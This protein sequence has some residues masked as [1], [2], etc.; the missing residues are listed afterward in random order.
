[1]RLRWFLPLL[2]LCSCARPVT[3]YV[4]PLIGSEGLGRVFVGPACPFG[5]VKPSPDCTTAPNSGWLPMPERVDGFAQTH[6]SGTG[7]GPKYGNI[8][9]M[10]QS[11]FDPA[12]TFDYRA[13]ETIQPGYYSTTFERSGIGVEVTAAPRVSAYRIHYPGEGEPVLRL[14]LD[15]FLGRSDTP[16]A[17]EAQEFVDAA[18]EVADECHLAGYQTIRGGWNN[19]APYTV[20]FCLQSDAPFVKTV[21]EGNVAQVAFDRKE[22]EVRIGI[23]YLGAERA[24]AN[25][26]EVEGLSFGGIRSACLAEW[27][28]LLSRVKVR[29]RAR[30][31]RMF[32]TALYHTMLMPVD[33]TGEWAPAGDEVYYDDYYALWDTYRT[34]LPLITLLDPARERDLVNALLTIYR[35]DGYLPDARSGNSNGRTQGG[36]NAEIV[37]ADAYVKGLE[38]I[39]YEEALRAMLHDAEVSPADDEAEGRGG[40]EEYRKLGYI[41]WGIPRAG[42]RTVEYAAC[43]AAIAT[44]AEGLGKEDIAAAYRRMSGNWKNL[45]R[46]DVT[47]DGVTGFIMPRDAS[48]AWLDHLPFGHSARL[49]LTYRYTPTMAEG[50]WY[51]KWWSAF[52]YEGSSWEY[53]LS[54]PHDVPGLVEMCGGEDAFDARLDRFFAGGYYNVAN[55]PSF[56]TPCLYHWIG[57]PDKTSARVLQIIADHFDDTPAGL[58]GND[59]SGAMSSWL[60]FHQMGLYP[61]AGTDRYVVHAPVFERTEIRLSN[62][63]RFIVKAKGLSN[64]RLHIREAR[65]D[66]RRLD[67]LFLTHA[68]LVRGGTLTLYMD[69]DAYVGLQPSRKD[70]GS[71]LE[72]PPYRM[73]CFLHGQKRRFDVDLVPQGDS[74]RLEWGI[75]RNLKGWRGSYTMTPQALESA[76]RLSFRM[77]EDGLQA[78]LDDAVF[79]LMPRAAFR[80]LRDRGRASFNGTQYLLEDSLEVACCRTLLHARDVQEGAEIWVLNNPSRPLIWRMQGNPAEV[81]WAFESLDPGY[82]AVKAHPNRAGGSYYAYPSPSLVEETPA[83][84][85]YKPFYVSH[86][87]RHGSRYLTRDDRYSRPLEFWRAQQRKGNLTPFG[88]DFLSRLETLWA[89]VEG[90]GGTLSAVGE[91]QHREIAGRMLDRYP[92]LFVPG[93]VVEATSST[94]GRCQASMDAFC[95]SLLSACP[96]LSLSRRSDEETMAVLVPKNPAID[97]L[98]RDDAPWRTTAYAR[99]KAAHIHPQRVLGSLLKDPG[100]LSDPMEVASDLYYLAVGLQDIPTGVDMSDIFTPEELY[101]ALRCVDSRMYY[102]HT[103]CPASGGTGPY[104]VRPLLRDF[105]DKADAAVAGT[106]PAAATLR[107]GHDSILIRLLSLLGVAECSALETDPEKYADAWQGWVVSPMAANLQLVLYRGRG[108]VKVKLLLNEHETSIPALGDG[109][110]YDWED[111]RAYAGACAREPDPVADL[112][113]RMEPGS[114]QRIAIECTESPEAFFEIDRRAGKPLIRADSPVHAAVGLNW[115]LKYYCGIHL[116][117][118]RMTASLPEDLPLP[119]KPERHTADVD[120]VYDFNYCTYSYSMAFW[121]WE[122]WERELDW[123]ALHGVD[124]PLAA[125]GDEC[126]WRNLL[127]RLGYSADEAAA[128]IPGPAYLAWFEM[129][130]IEGWGGPLPEGW[131]SCQEALQRQILARMKEWGMRPVLPGYSGMVPHDAAQRLGL[132]APDQGLWNQIQCPSILS[133]TDK[134][135][136]EIAAL[137][138]REQELLFGKADFYSMDPFH[139]SKNAGGVDFAKAGKAVLKAMKAVSPDAVW[140][141]QAWSDN[142]RDEMLAA[143]PKGDVLVLDLFSEC[144]PKWGLEGSVWYNEKGFQGHDWLFCLLQDFGGRVGLHGR[145]GELVENY[146]AARES[147]GLRGVGY[148]MEAIGSNPVMY[149]LM[150]ELPWRDT[151]VV[152]DW[153]RDYAFARY[154]VRDQVLEGA[155]ELLASSIYDARRPNNQQ[156]PVESVFCARPAWDAF[157]VY[158]RSKAEPYYD[159]LSVR[160]AAALMVSVAWRYRGNAHFEYDLV[161]LVRQALADRARE[162][163]YAHDSE[164]FMKALLAQDRLLGCRP[165]WMVGSWIAEALAKAEEVAPGDQ[166]VRALFER[167]AR[168]QLTTWGDRACADEGKLHD[169]AYKEW[170]GLLRDFYAKRWQ[171]F[172]DAETSEPGSGAAI[173]WYA[174]EEPWALRSDSYPAESLSNPVDTACEVFAQF[175]PGE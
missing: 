13:D 8:L 9:I 142:P 60:A 165:E 168:M 133:P 10:P 137:Y 15:F 49:P 84:K 40:L 69:S 34:S 155:W 32:Y 26:K 147:E 51:T 56:L 112:L 167:N 135:F 23:S 94:S 74:L 45:W 80:S 43:D 57:K 5:M 86:Y 111:F 17:R 119:E 1:M 138:Y 161:D 90:R 128:L 89:E 14:D 82:L 123:M 83:P 53:S 108:G 116:A 28:S 46:A 149:E 132:D 62:G 170:N 145:M 87:G 75:E 68:D 63:K 92:G 11:T 105:L 2:L 42:N 72:N 140:V 134:R 35:H 20:Y 98:D 78:V 18:V 130:N 151:L 6:V 102:V 66:G 146:A 24:R 143:L 25:L 120:F 36:S 109:P 124:L 114:S 136:A 141:L 91:R 107:F 58:P 163:L 118:D 38:G 162:L 127:L 110:Y 157:R 174:L 88:E 150:A 113:E 61:V 29:G 158:A 126:V 12:E 99:F 152:N 175:L 106:A 129:N 164:A 169:Y 154:G 31:K 103:M 121:D 153:V 67:S 160:Q 79:A 44:V 76:E 104:S 115:Y 22:V 71:Y 96:G 93:A 41:P 48:G 4:D 131:F 172:F 171:A 97:A 139:E 50:P 156:G 37:L 21:L 59:D 85:G 33:R 39:D 100:Q 19:G 54:V 122:R 3:D 52:F 70:S 95:D 73:T 16:G 125:V 173:D 64:G 144:R 101:G 27:S 148:T 30:D 81:D 65:M 159:I 77:P 166:S 117:W 7:G 47:D 55:E